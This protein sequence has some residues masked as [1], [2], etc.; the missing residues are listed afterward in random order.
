MSRFQNMKK[1]PLT[2]K[3]PRAARRKDKRVAPKEKALLCH[4]PIVPP[5]NQCPLGKVSRMP[6]IASF[7]D[8]NSPLDLFYNA[9]LEATR[10]GLDEKK[11]Q[12]FAMN[13]AN[14]KESRAYRDSLW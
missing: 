6:S 1:I 12:D 11:A 14:Q 3:S 5:L 4:P 10:R 7:L 13:R 2:L 9:K 8:Q